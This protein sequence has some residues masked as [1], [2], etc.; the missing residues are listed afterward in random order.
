MLLRLRSF[1]LLKSL[2]YYLEATVS[3]STFRFVLLYMLFYK[4][5]L[6][7]TLGNCHVAE[8]L[9]NS[10]ASW[11]FY[12]FA[13]PNLHAFVLLGIRAS[14]FLCLSTSFFIINRSTEPLCLCTHA[15]AYFHALATPLRLS[16]LYRLSNLAPRRVRDLAHLCFC[17][18]ALGVQVP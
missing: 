7:Q 2:T 8:S 4:N 6:I 13:L 15:T 17:A 11:Y 1:A 12:I 5:K 18:S 3:P 14:A 16:A 10:L 9:T